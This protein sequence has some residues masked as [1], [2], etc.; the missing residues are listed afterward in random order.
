ML[1]LKLQKNNMTRLALCVLIA[2]SFTGF[3]QSNLYNLSFADYSKN[4][5]YYSKDSSSMMN[6]FKC[7]DDLK[8]GKRNKITIAHYGGSHIQGGFWGDKLAEDFQGIGPFE[9]GGIYAFPYKL[10]KTNSPHY[11]KTF[12]TGTWKRFRCATNKEMCLNLGMA[13]IAAVTNDSSN[14]FGIKLQENKHHT[15]FNSLKLYYNFNPSFE[16]NLLPIACKFSRTDVKEKG[17]ILYEFVEFIDSVNFVLTRL[18][19]NRKDLML[20]GFSLENSKPGFYYAGFGVNGASSNSYLKCNLL[21]EQLQTLKPE[22]VIFSL[23]VNDTQDKDFSKT[24][25]IE[26]YDSL[27]AMVRAASPDC[28]ILFTTT[29]D[30]YIRRKTSNKRPIKA[31]EAMF[32]L[33][34]KHK[35]A[36][37][38]L[39]GVMGG[40]KSMYKWYKAGLAAR[41]KVHFNG[42]GYGIVGQLMFDAIYKSYKYNTKV[43]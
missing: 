37:W 23:G 34:E 14:T 1:F 7:V 26:H 13:G 22:L 24:G 9:G 4:K 20:Y 21:G 17:Y 38:D 30:N 5:I 43:K 15:K 27:I 25:Y 31:G 18:D 36:V 42:R 8:N 12:T 28:A 10:A 6:F 2:I 40:Y 33:M 41:D 35:A 29:S 16:I 32:E 19:T 39:Y 3:S 11:F